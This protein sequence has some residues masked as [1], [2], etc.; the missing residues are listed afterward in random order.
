MNICE[1]HAFNS[2]DKF[3][4]DI[5]VVDGWSS[6]AKEGLEQALSARFAQL[7]PTEEASTSALGAP[8]QP[9]ALQEQLRRANFPLVVSQPG[10]DFAGMEDWEVDISQLDIES[11][12]AQGSFGT[13][14][15]GY[16]CGQ[17]VAVKILRDVQVSDRSLGVV[18]CFGADQ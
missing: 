3:S 15:K 8:S 13:L 7:T 4:L 17:E 1:A 10:Q 18:A 12:I 6:Q 16:Y 2:T 11:K 9:S 5:F 14:Y